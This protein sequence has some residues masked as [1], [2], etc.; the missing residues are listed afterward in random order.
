MNPRRV[1][2]LRMR[3]NRRFWC[4]RYGGL[5][6]YCTQWVSVEHASLDHLIP[7]AIGGSDHR[8]NLTYACS[9][10]NRERGMTPLLRWLDGLTIPAERLEKLLV[11]Y[12]D[13]LIAHYSFRGDDLSLAEVIGARRQLPGAMTLSRAVDHVRRLIEEENAGVLSPWPN[14]RQSRSW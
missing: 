10:C 11:Q 4:D 14:V 2:Q 1:H 8:T 13:A 5:C 6:V 3:H 12:F 9:P 7:R